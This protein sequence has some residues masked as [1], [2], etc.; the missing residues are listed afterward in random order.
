[1]PAL[2]EKSKLPRNARKDAVTKKHPLRHSEVTQ[3]VSL[4]GKD[5]VLFLKELERVVRRY[6]AAVAAH[7]GQGFDNFHQKIFYSN[8]F[9]FKARSSELSTEEVFFPR[10]YCDSTRSFLSVRKILN[11]SGVRKRAKHKKH[12]TLRSRAGGGHLNDLY[13]QMNK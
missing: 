9:H 8:E 4:I 6:K 12:P 3:A 2:S 11:V 13:P 10:V 7:S 1:M 5:K